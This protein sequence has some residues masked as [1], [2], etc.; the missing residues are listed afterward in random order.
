MTIRKNFTKLHTL[1]Q[2]LQSASET[3]PFISY[4]VFID[5][6]KAVSIIEVADRHNKDKEAKLAAM[7]RST[8][9]APVG[10]TV[11]GGAAAVAAIKP[12]NASFNEG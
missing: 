8:S 12:Y 6:C 2:T 7:P 5:F 4:R 10:T 9:T 1:Y 3:Y 11:S